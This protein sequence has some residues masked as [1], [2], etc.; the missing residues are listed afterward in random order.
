MVNVI[1]KENP[2][3]DT[4]KK[5]LEFIWAMELV[6]PRK[7]TFYVKFDKYVFLCYNYI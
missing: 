4:L 2:I 1:K 7:L 3:N 6:K 5:K